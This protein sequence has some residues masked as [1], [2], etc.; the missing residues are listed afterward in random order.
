MG[1]QYQRSRELLRKM[2]PEDSSNM[3]SALIDID[4][5]LYESQKEVTSN[6]SAD[7]DANSSK[8]AFVDEESILLLKYGSTMGQ[9]EY[10]FA[11]FET[12]DF[13]AAVPDS[14][15]SRGNQK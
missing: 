15:E 7:T 13:S 1:E 3:L 8:D 12:A 5:D 4:R 2:Y 6:N 14:S 10:Q 11:S 9:Q